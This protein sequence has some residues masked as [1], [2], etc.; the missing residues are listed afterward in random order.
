MMNK[1]SHNSIGGLAAFCLVAPSS[2]YSFLYKRKEVNKTQQSSRNLLYGSLTPTIAARDLQHLRFTKQINSSTRSIGLI[3]NTFSAG[4]GL[5][6]QFG[7]KNCFRFKGRAFVSA[8]RSP[9]EDSVIKGLFFDADAQMTLFAPLSNTISML[10]TGGWEY[11]WAELKNRVS[12]FDIT[13]TSAILQLNGP[14][15]GVG[16][17]FRPSAAWTVESGVNYH[18]PMGEG[19]LRD[20]NS[21]N[22]PTDWADKAH[23]R[24]ARF[25]IGGYLEAT[26]Q[27]SEH[28]SMTLSLEGLSLSA[29][30]QH[31]GAPDITLTESSTES[32]SINYVNYGF[33]LNYTF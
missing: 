25:G 22:K 13:F 28:W 11:R 27:S 19:R 4:M 7:W 29:K 20:D 31:M 14:F 23:Y 3:N 12:G 9:V 30:G 16:V 2:G 1:F 10:L 18:L 8:T 33:G 32:M 26:W 24:G 5:N 21:G 6:P 15:A 17:N